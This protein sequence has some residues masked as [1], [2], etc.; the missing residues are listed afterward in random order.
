MCVPS[1]QNWQEYSWKPAGRILY[2]TLHSYF[3]PVIAVA[4]DMF[5]AT[6]KMR[7][8]NYD[9]STASEI[10]TAL[11]FKA[12]A[13]EVTFRSYQLYSSLPCF[14]KDF[15]GREGTV[16]QDSWFFFPRRQINEHRVGCSLLPPFLLL[17]SLELKPWPVQRLPVWNDYRIRV[18]Q[19]ITCVYKI[20]G[21][22]LC[23]LTHSS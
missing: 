23:D 9:T 4:K 19:S 5:R 1:G 3:W 15:S 12:L 6:V 21:T 13:T 7:V 8:P 18:M 17:H 16:R 11:A 22:L 10:N 14:Q 20:E 2:P